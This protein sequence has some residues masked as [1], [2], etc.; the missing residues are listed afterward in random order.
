MS[1]IMWRCRGELLLSPQDVR[2]LKRGAL[3]IQKKVKFT[4]KVF[5]LIAA[6]ACWSQIYR[7]TDAVNSWWKLSAPTVWT[8][9]RWLCPSSVSA[10]HPCSVRLCRSQRQQRRGHAGQ[11][12]PLSQV[13]GFIRSRRGFHTESSFLDLFHLSVCPWVWNVFELHFSFYIL[14]GAEVDA[15][16]TSICR[17]CKSLNGGRERK[18]EGK[19]DRK[20]GFERKMSL[21]KLLM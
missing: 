20:S 19:K 12:R 17:S 15:A 5:K 21:I 8:C 13:S 4:N 9:R 18:K 14:S 3:L 1:W 11:V 10:A 7:E 2:K 6:A 16:V